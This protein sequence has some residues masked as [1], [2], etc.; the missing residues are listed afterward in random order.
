MSEFQDVTDVRLFNRNAELYEMMLE[1]IRNAQQ[2]I[3]FE[4]YRIIKE[5]IGALFRDA[6]AEA[7]LRNVKVVLLIDAWGTGTSMTFFAPVIKNGGQVR[8]FNTFRPGTR[9]FT[10]SH[11]RN[12]RKILSIDDKICYI[13]SSN[14]SHYSLVWRELNL[15]INGSIAKPF[16]YI[17]DLDF[18][19][20]QKYTY[21]KKVFTRVIHFRGF[22]II[23]DVPS[24][25]KQKVM[26]KYLYL[27]RNAKESVYIET[28]YF[29]PGYRLRKAMAEAVE[30][31]ITVTIVLPKH[32]DVG[33]VDV[34]RN[35]YLG[36]IHKSGIHLLYY[37]PNNLHSKLMIIDKSTFCVGSTNFD[38]RSFRYMHEVV[39][40]GKHEFIMKHLIAHRNETLLTVQDFDYQYWKRRPILE[41]IISWLLVPFRY[42][43]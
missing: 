21:T 35:R 31:G 36:Q 11:R 43:F 8:I 9:M 30:R 33:L 32:S 38:Y 10:Q 42:L 40:C 18:K 29:L 17:V 27:I 12:H 22:E 26:R 39:L 13:G 14:I 4:M 1:D 37:Y 6:L 16:R 19:T 5:S 23:R 41:K 34:L 15:R 25:Y 2:C 24:I 28:P 7:A 20:H 3:Y